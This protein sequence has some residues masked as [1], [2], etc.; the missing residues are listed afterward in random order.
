MVK[1]EVCIYK[2]EVKVLVFGSD[3]IVSEDVILESAKRCHGT[4]E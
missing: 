3:C 2:L 4:M 1:T